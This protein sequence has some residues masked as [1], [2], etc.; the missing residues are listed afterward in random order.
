MSKKDDQMP[1]TFPNKWLKV[2]KDLPEF[3]DTADAATADDLKKII[4]TCEGNISLVEKEKEEDNKLN[5]AK[6]LVKE[7]SAVYRDG[8]KCQTAKIKY[9]IFLLEGKGEEIGDKE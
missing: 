1:T 2:L 5:G 8:I 6:E 3:K 7:Y 9:A 4:V